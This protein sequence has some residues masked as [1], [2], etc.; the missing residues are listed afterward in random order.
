MAHS[1]LWH[2]ANQL[3]YTEFYDACCVQPSCTDL[4]VLENISVANSSTA[5]LLNLVEQSSPIDPATM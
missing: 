1:V 3:S 4:E 2:C 5:Q